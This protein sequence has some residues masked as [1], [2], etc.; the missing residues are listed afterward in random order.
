MSFRA[1]QRV[2]R[3]GGFPLEAAETLTSL[4]LRMQIMGVDI[5]PRGLLSFVNDFQATAN[6][7]LNLFSAFLTLFFT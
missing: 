4:R 1:K 7:L 3:L 6:D 5:V 2:P